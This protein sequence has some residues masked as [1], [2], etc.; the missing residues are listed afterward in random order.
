MNTVTI[1]EEALTA[2]ATQ[3]AAEVQQEMVDAAP[4]EGEATAVPKAEESWR[5]LTHPMMPTVRF[6]LLPQWGLGEEELR[7]WAESLGQCLDQV[8]PGGI[9]GKYGCWVRLI[10]STSGIIGARAMANG[11]RLPGFG[12]KKEKPVEATDGNAQSK[13]QAA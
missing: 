6:I 9:D 3:V 11:G 4:V 1:S 5:E 13:A 12:P 2:E 8:F 10:F 7:E